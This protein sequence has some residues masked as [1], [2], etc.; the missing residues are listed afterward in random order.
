MKPVIE[1]LISVCAGLLFSTQSM[2][3]LKIANDEKNSSSSSSSQ[4]KPVTAIK[5]ELEKPYIMGS[6]Q[7]SAA[8]QTV[9]SSDGNNLDNQMLSDNN[10]NN[11]NGQF[12]YTLGSESLNRML[13]DMLARPCSE[14]M[15]LPHIEPAIQL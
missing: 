3:I 7:I 8:L 12:E 6:E 2:R 10:N 13:E 1:W 15:E 14:N 9:L 4:T 11:N 5:D